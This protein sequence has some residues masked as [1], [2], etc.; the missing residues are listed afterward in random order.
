MDRYCIDR[1]TLLDAPTLSTLNNPEKHTIH[2]LVDVT[3]CSA[4]NYEILAEPTGSNSS[5]H[6]RAFTLDSG[7]HSKA[8]S[9]ARELGSTSHGC[10]T[11]GRGMQRKGFRATVVGIV[12][13]GNPPTL[14]VQ[15]MFNASVGCD[16]YGGVALLP[17][18][19][20]C[21]Q[22]G[23]EKWILA[24]GSIMMFSW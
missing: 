1:G 20:N 3:A 16:S 17:A 14:H 5:L 8:V 6:C 2:C 10:S 13:T 23:N 22:G 12:G 7:G 21:E 11:C 24:H 9:L 4:S 15:H 19:L 18:N